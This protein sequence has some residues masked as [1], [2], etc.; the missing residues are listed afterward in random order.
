M[1]WELDKQL[2]IQ[3]PVVI[4]WCSKRYFFKKPNKVKIVERVKWRL[5]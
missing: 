2:G 5:T 3:A 1:D 4:N